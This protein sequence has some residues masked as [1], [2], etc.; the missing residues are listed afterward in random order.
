MMNHSILATDTDRNAGSLIGRPDL[1][2]DALVAA[3][4]ETQALL[5]L[6]GASPEA[7]LAA[8]RAGDAAALNTMKSL[9]LPPPVARL[10][11]PVQV[12]K[13]ERR[14]IG[15]AVLSP[16]PVRDRHAA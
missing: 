6:T 4:A 14:A 8:A 5:G 13:A 7:T 9:M 10:Q 2:D 11:M 3:I 16:V 12:L 1:S 15:S